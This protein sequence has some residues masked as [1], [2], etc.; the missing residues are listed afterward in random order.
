V[1]KIFSILFALVLVVSL[2]L[3]TALP[4]VAQP[5]CYLG[6]SST[7]GGNVTTPGEGA[8]YYSAGTVVDLVATPDGGYQFVNWTG[9]VGTIANVNAASTTITM[10]SGNY[11]ITANFEEIPKY[12]LITSSTAGGSVT[13]PGEG[14]FLYDV[15]TVVDLVATPDGGYR[16]VNWTGTVGTIAN[17]NAASTTITMSGNYSITANFEEIPEY[18]LIISSTAGGSVTTPGEGFFIYEEG[19]VVDLVATPDG[20]YQFVNWTG[21]VGTIA[22]VNAASTTITMSSGNYSITANFAYTLHMECAVSPNPTEVGQETYFMAAASG[23]VPP[24]SWVWEINEV[25]VATTQNTTYTFTSAGVFYSVCVTVTDSLDNKEVCCSNVTVNP[26]PSEQYHLTISS[27]AGGSVTT[28][29]E[30]T[31]TYDAGTVVNLVAPPDADYQ[32]VTWSGD[33]GAIADINDPTTTITMNGHYSITAIFAYGL[34]VECAVS[35]NPT[36]VGQVTNFLAAAS[37]GVPPYSWSWRI[38]GT[39]VATVQNTTHV[40][41]AA[42]NYTVC[43]TV[44]DSL[45]NEELCCSSVTVNP[46]PSGA[47]HLTISSTAGGSVNTPGEGTFNYT[48]GTVVDLAAIPD[49]GYEFVNWTGDV[50]TIADVNAATTIITMQGNYEITARFVGVGAAKTETV[51]GGGTVDATEEAD[52]EVAVNGTATVTV[53]LYEE[54]PGGPPPTGFSSL[55]KYIDVYVPDTTEANELEIRLYY[56]DAELA[57]ADIDEESLQLFWWDGDDWVACSDSGVN[58]ASTNGHSGY[59]WAQIR[60][61]T[62]PPLDQL[63][64]TAWGGYGH[65]STPPQPCGC[66]IATA[67]YGTDTTKE[68]DILREFRDV[69]L[70]PNSLGAG[71]VSL[72][73]KISPSIANFISQHEV[74]RTAVRVCFVD[75][76]VKI[77]IWSHDLWSARG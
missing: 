15:G 63:Q 45:D 49:V 24:Y 54:N 32:F 12:S 37:G 66:F 65:P 31:F 51:T 36:E 41:A 2:E 8:F 56:T 67:A 34:F 1:K 58:T 50:G 6:I 29:G 68:I 73:Y 52:T 28:P 22:N 43:V 70:L 40:F 38:N 19:T 75:P 30:G 39:E 16:F 9:T 7:A 55:D 59:I 44:T 17:V 60:N 14:F 26:A 11:S 74:L 20:G 27:T 71:F 23:G 33:V 61:D 42:G 47:Y 3:V 72:Y 18:P 48:A 46:A 4:V 62:T 13:T 57:A 25:P 64:G 35:P 5:L 69:V 21:N 77:L 53:A 10:S 76:I